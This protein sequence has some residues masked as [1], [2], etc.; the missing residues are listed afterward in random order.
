[1]CDRH[2]EAFIAVADSS[3]FLK[4][5]ERLSLSPSALRKQVA[6]LEDDLGVKLFE[7]SPRG[8]K[9]TPGGK[10]IYQSAKK[11]IQECRGD[12]KRGQGARK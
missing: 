10:Y 11:I 4:V 12:I 8:V 6:L 7:R 3:S 5:S 1:M 9:L 2:L